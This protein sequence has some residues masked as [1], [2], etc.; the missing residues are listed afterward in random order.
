MTH[1]GLNNEVYDV[2]GV[3][4]ALGEVTLKVERH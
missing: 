2:P 1:M 4:V 3:R